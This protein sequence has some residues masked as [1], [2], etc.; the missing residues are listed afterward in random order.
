MIGCS[1]PNALLR[2]RK[3]HSAPNAEEVREGVI[4][5]KIAAHAA[6]IARRRPRVR[7]RDDALSRAA[8]HSIG[9]SNSAWRSTRPGRELQTSRI[10]LTIQSAEFCAM[11]AQFAR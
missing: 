1:A 9:A 2:H 5:Y 11:C 4:A 10:P 6:D 7:D 3:E 8:S